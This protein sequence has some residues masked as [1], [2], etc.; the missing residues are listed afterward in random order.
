MI[1]RVEIIVWPSQD[2]VLDKLWKVFKTHWPKKSKRA[3][4][5][6][7]YPLPEADT[8]LPQPS[9]S[10]DELE[11]ASPDVDL[12][13][14]LGVPTECVERMTPHKASEQAEQKQANTLPPGDAEKTQDEIRKERIVF[15]Q[16]LGLVWLQLLPVW[17]CCG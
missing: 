7:E 15:L 3:V 6:D 8:E 10:L 9:A 14:A 4:E 5:D 2:P 12:A 17:A 13:K 1:V 16:T 11:P